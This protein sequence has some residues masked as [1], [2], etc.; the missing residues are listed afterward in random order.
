MSDYSITPIKAFS[1]NYIWVIHNDKSA[2][3][4][5]P[6]EASGVIKFLQQNNLQLET[7]LLTHSH[8]DHIGGVQQLCDK[9]GCQVIDNSALQLSDNQ[10]INLPSFPVVQVLLTPG[11]TNEHV[12]YLFDNKHLF[13]GDVLFGLGCGRVFT[14]NYEAAHS[15]LCKIK[16]LSGNILCYPAHEYTANN[17][18]FTS[19]I[20]DTPN[21]YAKYAKL[22]LMKL[23]TLQNSL[24]TT[25]E[26]ELKYNLFLRCDD[27]NIWK[28]VGLKSQQVINNEF[29]CFKQLRLLRNNF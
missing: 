29:D 5:D 11:H 13:C 24:P 6:G 10:V 9:Y 20:D 2:I 7:I 18:R 14:D 22:L 3:A 26:N 1:D 28:M 15:S 23:T 4:I 19:S 25:L 12:V 16:Q 27:V 17:L 8:N 21:Y